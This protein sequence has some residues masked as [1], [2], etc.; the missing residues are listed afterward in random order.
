MGTTYFIIKSIPQ[1]IQLSVVFVYD[2]PKNRQSN[3]FIFIDGTMVLLLL[4]TNDGLF[5]QHRRLQKDDFCTSLRSLL[6]SEA[7]TET[8]HSYAML[9]LAKKKF[10]IVIRVDFLVLK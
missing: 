1:W 9:R 5:L 6:E 2:S 4:A 8:A 3:C 7:K 10:K